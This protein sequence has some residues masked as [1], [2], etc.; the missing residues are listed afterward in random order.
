MAAL[1]HRLGAW[2]YLRRRVVLVAWL[3]V[4]VGAGALAGNV[5]GSSRFRGRG[6][7]AWC[8]GWPK[9]NGPG[10]TAR[11][12]H[13]RMHRH[14]RSRAW[15]LPSWRGGWAVPRPHGA[16]VAGDG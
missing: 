4:L 3:A 13:E 10:A 5:S 2:A 9:R 8:A 12:R 1:L 16:E 15:R 11:A 14:C 7:G 6:A